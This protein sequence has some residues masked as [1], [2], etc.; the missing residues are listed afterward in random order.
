MRNDALWLVKLCHVSCNIQSE[1][2]IFTL[3]VLYVF[4]W[5]ALENSIHILLKE[6]KRCN[7]NQF[8]ILRIILFFNGPFPASFSLF[9]SFQYTVDSIQ[10]FNINKFLPMTGFEPRTSGIKSSTNWATITSLNYYC[11]WLNL[12]GF[13]RCYFLWPWGFKLWALIEVFK[14]ITIP[15]FAC[16]Y[17]KLKCSLC[18]STST[19]WVLRKLISMRLRKQFFARDVEEKC[20]S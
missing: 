3:K 9:S 15:C 5:R 16:Q 10:M 8:F 18:Q 20:W 12:I 4:G 13:T 7:S 6:I 1:C 19:Y 14:I 2:F 11:Y 17:F